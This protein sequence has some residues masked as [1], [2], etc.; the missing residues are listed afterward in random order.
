MCPLWPFHFVI[1]YV[2]LFM[3]A[4]F[5]VLTAS[6]NLSALN[7]VVLSP[8]TVSTLRMSE[9]KTISITVS[10]ALLSSEDYV[11]I[12][13][14]PNRENVVVCYPTV[15]EI[16]KND[17]SINQTKSFNL[18]GDFLGSTDVSIELFSVNSTFF[19]SRYPFPRYC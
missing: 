11:R 18:T 16:R 9:T 10:N 5:V 4:H 15:H 8:S 7:G 19:V 3:S 14:K 2:L 6:K 1:L 12:V 13:I 17:Y